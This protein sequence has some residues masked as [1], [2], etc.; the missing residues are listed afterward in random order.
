MVVIAGIALYHN[1]TGEGKHMRSTMACAAIAATLLVSG[2]AFAADITGT[3]REGDKTA[4]GVVTIQKAGEEYLVDVRTHCT[5]I[6]NNVVFSCGFTGR[7]KLSGGVIQAKAVSEDTGEEAVLPIHFARFPEVPDVKPGE[8]AIVDENG[9][10]DR[11]FCGAGGAAELRGRFT[12]KKQA[13]Q[14]SR[15]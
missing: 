15:P 3:Y 7:G 10:S 6:I 2:F 9:L 8:I 13:R 1:R 5:N 11:G 4:G 12:K 14:K